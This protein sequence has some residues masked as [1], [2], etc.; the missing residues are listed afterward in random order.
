[1]ASYVTWYGGL[2][3]ERFL[4]A[5]VA[6]TRNVTRAA[7]RYARNNHPWQNRTGRTEE[8]IFALEPVV[9]GL[10]VK[11]VWGGASPALYLEMGTSKMPA[12]PFLRPAAAATYRLAHFAGELR[13][14]LGTGGVGSFVSAAG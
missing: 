5:A 4:A 14:Q 6:T 2:V 13:L 3:E 11:G 7:A 9:E 10:M 1:M 8:G 12:Y